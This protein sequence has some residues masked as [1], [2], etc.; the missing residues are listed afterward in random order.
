METGLC[1]APTGDFCTGTVGVAP[2]VPSWFLPL[3]LTPWLFRFIGP[4]TAELY[5]ELGHTCCLPLEAGKEVFV[6]GDCCSS[7]QC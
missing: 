7:L 1:A 5:A 3:I 6:R 4:R 2:L